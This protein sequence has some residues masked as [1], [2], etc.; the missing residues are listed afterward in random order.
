MNGGIMRLYIDGR[1]NGENDINEIPYNQ[2]RHPVQ[3]A[4]PNW[5]LGAQQEEGNSVSNPPT[6]ISIQRPFHGYL[7]DVRVYDRRLSEEEVM[8]LAGL[9]PTAQNYY[10]IPVPYIY[11]DIYSP[12]AQGSKR[13]NFKDLAILAQDWMESSLWPTGF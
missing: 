6:P 12:E 5:S 8:Y 1:Q 2:T 9:G 11:S 13:V 3:W 10:P 7:D 4:D